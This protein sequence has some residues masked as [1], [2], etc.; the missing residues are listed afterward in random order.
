MKRVIPLFLSICST[1][2]L[3]AQDTTSA[4]AMISG[5]PVVLA[6]DMKPPLAISSTPT[7]QELSDAFI[8]AGMGQEDPFKVVALVAERG[9]DAVLALGEFLFAG[10]Q[11]SAAIGTMQTDTGS[12][13]VYGLTPRKVYAVIALEVIGTKSAFETL[14]QVA[15][16]HPEE[17]VRTHAL[18]AIAAS[19]L[20]RFQDGA[21]R[22]EPNKEV[23]HLLLRYADDCTKSPYVEGSLAGVARGGLRSWAE[24]D[25]GEVNPAVKAITVQG[26]TMS[27][28]Q[29]R[30]RW[31]QG[32]YEKI[33]WSVEKKRFELK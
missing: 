7:V 32:N 5:D 28:A 3:N 8:Q 22:G 14:F 30:E 10:P 20:A 1:V 11:P 31:W 13:Q 2:V 4:T 21:I 6:A 19:F 24:I 33:D 29:Y 25:L 12:V 9:E 17:E 16:S 27:L 26:E 15:A 18:K 23:I